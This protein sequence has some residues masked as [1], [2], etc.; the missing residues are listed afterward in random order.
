MTGCAVSG[1]VDNKEQLFFK[2]NRFLKSSIVYVL[3][4]CYEEYQLC[5]TM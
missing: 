3:S 4:D 5:N 2:C 1:I